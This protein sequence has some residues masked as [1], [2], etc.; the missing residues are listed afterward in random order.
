MI[1]KLKEELKLLLIV[2]EVVLTE[3]D[4]PKYN[5]IKVKVEPFD[6]HKC[7]RCWNY[8]TDKDMTDKIC[9]RCHEVVN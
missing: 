6:G 8:F 5:S 9:N 3:E 2:S 7:E 1:N 4:L